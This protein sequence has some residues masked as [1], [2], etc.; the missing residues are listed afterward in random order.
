MA[1]LDL[2]LPR[3]KDVS[4]LVG[5]LLDRKVAIKLVDPVAYEQAVTGIF[6]S[7]H[8]D[9]GIVVS[10]DIELA[11]YAG[12][13]LSLMPLENAQGGING[14]EVPEGVLENYREVINVLGAL[15]NR[16]DGTHVKLW[17][18]LNETVAL[19]P[20]LPEAL[21]QVDLREDFSVEIEGYGMGHM[22]FRIWN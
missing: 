22:S 19:P 3:A 6:A 12:A 7:E 17:Y 1:V 2:Y 5:E 21:D 8:G 18:V 14:R 9:S 10:S 11:N 20:G 15:L 16:R 13:A 4:Q